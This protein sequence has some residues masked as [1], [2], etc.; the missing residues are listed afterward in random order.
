MRRCGKNHRLYRRPGGDPEDTRS[1]ARKGSP[2]RTGF[3]ATMPGPTATGLSKPTIQT[4]GCYDHGGAVSCVL[5]TRIGLKCIPLRDEFSR[6]RLILM[7][8]RINWRRNWKTGRKTGYSSTSDFWQYSVY[9]TYEPSAMISLEWFARNVR[10]VWEGGRRRLIMYLETVASETSIPSFNSSP[11]I[12][13]APHNGLARHMRR[14]N[15]RI[16]GSI[17]GRPR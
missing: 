4:I 2:G 17:L 9:F 14:I 11:W 10:Q 13:G 1:L 3:A 6:G 16:S 12:H 15:C 8:F 7:S 5:Q